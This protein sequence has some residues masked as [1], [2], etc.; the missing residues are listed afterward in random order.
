[1]NMY[2]FCVDELNEYAN[3]VKDALYKIYIMTV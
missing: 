1:M 3:Q 2:S